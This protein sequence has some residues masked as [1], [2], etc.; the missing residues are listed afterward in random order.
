M[1]VVRNAAFIPYLTGR[2]AALLSADWARP[3]PVVFSLLAF[4][5]DGAVT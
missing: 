1:V 4:G 2:P 5:C 3:L